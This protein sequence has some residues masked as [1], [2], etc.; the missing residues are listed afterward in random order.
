MLSPCEFIH[1]RKIWLISESLY[2][3]NHLIEEYYICSKTYKTRL[4]LVERE[5]ERERKRKR[6]IGLSLFVTEYIFSW[7]RANIFCYR[8]IRVHHTDTYV[9]LFK[10]ISISIGN[11]A[12]TFMFKHC[13]PIS[14]EIRW[15]VSFQYIVYIGVEKFLKINSFFYYY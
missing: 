15:I 3:N 14:G 7:N 4:F 8:Y 10:K 11:R 12:S 2:N 9:F 13:E 6:E 1:F 5:R